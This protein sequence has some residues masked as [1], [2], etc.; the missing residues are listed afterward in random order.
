VKAL[1]VDPLPYPAADRLV[2]V[3]VDNPAQGFNR[4]YNSYPR[5]LDWRADSRTLESLA[6][7]AFMAPALTG[8]GEAE[9][10]PRGEPSNG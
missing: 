1:V 10:P 7:F 8:S 3:W 9:Q 5:L 4:D 2:M 6:G